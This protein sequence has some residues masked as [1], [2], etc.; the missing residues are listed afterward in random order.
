MYLLARWGPGSTLSTGAALFAGI[1]FTMWPIHVAALYGHL[2]K[3]FVGLLPLCVLAGLLAYDPSRSRGWTL[4]P[5]IA[6]LLLLLHN[7][8]QFA[9]GVIALVVCAAAELFA[10]DRGERR[11][12]LVRVV[13]SGAVAVAITAPLL[14]AVARAARDPN[15]FTSVGAYSAYYA[16]DLLQLGVPSIHQASVGRL[17]YPAYGDVL[18]EF[19]RRSAIDALT[20]REGWYGSGVETAVTVPAT[21]LALAI[22]A[23]CGRWPGTRRWLLFGALFAVLAL[24]PDLR[25]AGRSTIPL[26]YRWLA[27][28]PGFDWMRTPGRFMIIA[29]VGFSIA[30]ALGLATL[31]AR[32]PRP[33]PVVALVVA[34][35]LGETWPR[36]WPQQVPPPVPAFYA[37]IAED[38]DRYAVLDL[39]VGA[40]VASHGSAY[41]Y[42]QLTHH[43]PIAWGYL[44]RPYVDYPIEG[45]D[46]LF[47]PGAPDAIGTRER[48][49]ELGYRYVVWHKRHEELFG[50]RRPEIVGEGR[51]RSSGIDAHTD[52]FVARAFAGETPVA[53][54]DLVTVYRLDPIDR[55]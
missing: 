52:P 40:W 35:L 3:V 19:T 8:Q 53:D 55:P 42:Y 32:S 14:I 41:Q 17:V 20:A 48:L 31:A 4:A 54:D 10:R 7:G 21:S 11:A 37:R 43:K 22:V 6:L 47:Q 2:E 27:R 25:I 33:M 9:F 44:S 36:P 50:D 1:V 46:A 5:G 39:P 28:A 23:F 30:A 13:A 45:L 16:P 51:Y 38:A 12:F 26:P 15:L 24:G 18:A 49:V 29:S 34:L